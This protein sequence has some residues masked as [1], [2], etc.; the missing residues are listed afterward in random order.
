MQGRTIKRS[1]ADYKQQVQDESVARN[2][3]LVELVINSDIDFSS[4]GWSKKVAVL[5]NK[6]PQK[7]K[8]WMTRYMPDLYN[9]AK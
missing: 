6:R 7:V 8:Y 9:T 4:T 2:Q 5:I 3:H 1:Y